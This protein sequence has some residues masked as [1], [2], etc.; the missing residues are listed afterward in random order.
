MIIQ[1]I[2]KKYNQKYVLKN[3]T[4]TLDQG[5]IIGIIGKNGAG[6]TLSLIHI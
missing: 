1:D 4:F 6:K 3:I 5:H 2:N